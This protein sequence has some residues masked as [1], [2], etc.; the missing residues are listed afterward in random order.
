ML[1]ND[2]KITAFNYSPD[3][4]DR[5]LFVTLSDSTLLIYSA[6]DLSKEIITVSLMGEDMISTSA[7]FIP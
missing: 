3:S 7:D 5:L 1:F 4:P 2:H 6:N